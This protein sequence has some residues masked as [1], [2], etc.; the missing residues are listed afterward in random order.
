MNTCP[1]FIHG[2]IHYNVKDRRSES[3]GL[4]VDL[5]IVK[6]KYYWSEQE[7]KVKPAESK[8]LQGCL[9]GHLGSGTVTKNKSLSFSK[10]PTMLVC[11]G[12]FLEPPPSP[13]MM[14]WHRAGWRKKR[15]KNEPETSL[16][17]TS[18]LLRSN[19]KLCKCNRALKRSST[20]HLKQN[21]KIPIGSKLAISAFSNTDL[22][23]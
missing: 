17:A 12:L 2:P 15:S 8:N 9:W 22:K 19:C 13:N 6:E 23:H 10:G 4:K 20:N 21:K 18:D 3:C 14:E 7:Q 5:R 16:S 1:R 11:R